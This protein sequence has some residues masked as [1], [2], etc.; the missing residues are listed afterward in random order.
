MSTVAA[1]RGGTEL[2]GP[3]AATS[4]PGLLTA[5]AAVS[6]D[7]VAWRQKRLGLWTETSWAQ[8]EVRAAAYAAGFGDRGIE[9][10]SR[11]AMIVGPGIEA[12]AAGLGLQGMGAVVV[13]FH[14]G[15]SAPELGA[16]LA[17]A[18]VRIAIAEDAE[19]LATILEAGPSVPQ[20]REVFVVDPRGVPATTGSAARLVTV[21]ERSDGDTAEGMLDSW[22]A[23]VD[24]LAPDGPA[25]LA[26]TVGGS[27]VPRPVTLT[28]TNLMTATRALADAVPV[29]SDDEILSYLP[30]SHVLECVLSV[31][32]APLVGAVVSVGDGPDGVLADLR[33]VRPTVLLG[34]PSLW[35]RI[36]E[37]VQERCSRA[38]WLKR[39]VLEAGLRRGRRRLAALRSGARPGLLAGRLS[40]RRVRTLLGLDRI[41]APLSAFASL[42]DETADAL[43]A[44]GLAVRQCYGT[45]DASGLLTVEPADTVQ[46]GSVG[47]PVAA[48]EVH[49]DEDGELLARGAQIAPDALDAGGWLHTGDRARIDDGALVRLVGR[50]EDLIVT[51]SGARVDAAVVAEVLERLPLVRRA[52]IAG[53]G[54]PSIGA[55][56]E[57]DQVELGEWA[58]R[59]SAPFSALRDLLEWP[60]LHDELTHGVAAAN[61]ELAP[62][63]RVREFRA[64]PGP[65]VLHAELTGT[66]RLRRVAALRH[67]A[68]LVEEMYRA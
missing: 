12:T 50:A 9:P 11:V 25:L 47:H 52:V 38:G 57:L 28:H 42:A 63:A 35:E 7:R 27:G 19:Q 22:R 2:A 3:A 32:V 21:A 61:D 48:T 10:G 29:V 65:L 59:R 17:D 58:S 1:A 34:V 24:R 36:A 45:A 13:S 14:P 66:H 8:L 26:L 30:P 6:P 62:E 55:L 40:T 16:L 23:S 44:L 20:L 18:D 37:R 60:E 39:K 68:R 56:L 51:A 4:L 67:H 33:D 5:R 53:D 49:I 54:R 64:L 46:P 31:G 41:R 15:R 43:G